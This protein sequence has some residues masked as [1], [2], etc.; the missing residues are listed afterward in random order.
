MPPYRIIF[1][2]MEYAD[3]NG[4]EINA[5]PPLPWLHYQVSP[6]LPEGLK[7]QVQ[8]VPMATYDYGEDAHTYLDLWFDYMY[9]VRQ[10][11]SSGSYQLCPLIS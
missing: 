5:W 4:S 2:Y 9:V 11:F 7:A 3:R 1:W 8:I 10:G 6:C